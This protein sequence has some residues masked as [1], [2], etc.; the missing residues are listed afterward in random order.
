MPMRAY[1]H[2]IYIGQ[3]AN[4]LPIVGLI[5]LTSSRKP[6]LLKLIQSKLYIRWINI[7]DCYNLHIIDMQVV[8][9]GFFPPL[10]KSDKSNFNDFYWLAGQLKNILLIRFTLRFRKCEHMLIRCRGADKITEYGHDTRSF[11]C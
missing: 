6:M 5:I 8:N 1:V 10:A 3:L 11:N 2:Q 4:L 7:T 9:K